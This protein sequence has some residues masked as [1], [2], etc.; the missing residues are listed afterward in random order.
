MWY[1]SFL[2]YCA[3]REYL[4]NCCS[5]LKVGLCITSSG[6]PSLRTSLQGVKLCFTAIPLASRLRYFLSHLH[7]ILFI[8]VPLSPSRS[9]GPG[10]RKETAILLPLQLLNQDCLDFS[11]CCLSSF[12]NEYLKLSLD[13]NLFAL[14]VW[15]KQIQPIWSLLNSCQASLGQLR[16]CYW[17]SEAD[18]TF[19]RYIGR[20][21]RLEKA[22]FPSPSMPT[23]LS[24]SLHS[25]YPFSYSLFPWNVPAKG[26][27]GLAMVCV[28]SS[29]WECR[30]PRLRF[31]L[32]SA[33]LSGARSQDADDDSIQYVELSQ[34]KSQ[35]SSNKVRAGL[36]A[37]P[38]LSLPGLSLSNLVTDVSVPTASLTLFRQS[39]MLTKKICAWDQ[40]NAGHLGEFISIACHPL[41]L[42]WSF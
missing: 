15:G 2:E 14:Y 3:H 18:C 41:V 7:P 30:F 31:N 11:T 17:S 10:W 21:W 22:G 33:C 12:G 40:Y 32:H 37:L 9:L 35:E 1:P 36:C 23:N 5:S 29:G 8:L 26:L 27:V 34:Q 42:F 38:G 13:F 6:R 25:W 4:G 39:T 19:G 28:H 16:L 24:F 20:R